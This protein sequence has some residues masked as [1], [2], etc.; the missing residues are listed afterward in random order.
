MHKLM[1]ASRK[2]PPG[3]VESNLSNQAT[4][5][6]PKMADT[7]TTFRWSN[8]RIRVAWERECRNNLSTSASLRSPEIFLFLTRVTRPCQWPSSNKFWQPWNHLS[9]PWA[10]RPPEP[11]W[12]AKAS[13][14][15]LAEERSSLPRKSPWVTQIGFANLP[16][17][18]DETVLKQPT[19]WVSHRIG[20]LQ[21]LLGLEGPEG[22]RV[23]GLV[24]TGV[25]PL[26]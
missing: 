5:M 14:A 24:S 21:G 2:S 8:S 6:L 1:V 23:A 26:Q 15:P 7:V 19:F 16:T 9:W 22:I 20:G 3:Q 10:S 25:H 18:F 11:E 12:P 13:S 4:S 17:N